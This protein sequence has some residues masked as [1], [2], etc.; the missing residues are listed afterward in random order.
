MGRNLREKFDF[1]ANLL[2][3]L[4]META[5]LGGLLRC[6]LL[7]LWTMDALV[8]QYAHWNVPDRMNRQPVKGLLLQFGATLYNFPLGYRT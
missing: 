6:L 4:Q 1:W 5:M 8:F 7:N 3:I 2:M